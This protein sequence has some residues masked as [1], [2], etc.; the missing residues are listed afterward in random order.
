MAIR[1]FWSL[2]AGLAFTM[3]LAA[4]NISSVLPTLSKNLLWPGFSFAEEVWGGLHGHQPILMG[5]A[6][7]VVL[8]AALTF[9]AATMW[10]RIHS[11]E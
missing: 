2:F 3:V 9:I 1:A 7:N 8:Y 5:L 4:L 6:A 10:K 11:P